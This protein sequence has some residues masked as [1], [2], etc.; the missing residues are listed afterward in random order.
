MVPD[1]P[2]YCLAG[3]GHQLHTAES[4]ARGYGDV[5][6]E[7]RM[8]RAARSVRAVAPP[9]RPSGAPVRHEA[10]DDVLI[11]AQAVGAVSR[12]L[13]PP[14]HSPLPEP[15]RFPTDTCDYC[16]A[17]IIWAVTRN[18]TAMPVDA[19]PSAG[20]NVQLVSQ[21]GNGPPLARVLNTAEQFGKT[22]LRMPHHA[23]CPKGDQLRV[24][25]GRRHHR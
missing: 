15:P 7:R 1:E 4:R 18:G 20:A 21:A 2:V 11:G 16:P 22:N 17:T 24:Q 9:A 8:G 5:C 23:T 12:D 6:W 14:Q 3:C 13:P 10:E 19:Q 25:R